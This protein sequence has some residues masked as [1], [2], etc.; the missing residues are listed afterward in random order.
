MSA[1]VNAD[2][3][4]VSYPFH[5]MGGVVSDQ[6]LGCVDGA[7]DVRHLDLRNESGCVG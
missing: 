6:V 4:A 1:C 3:H 7:Q 5:H 2:N